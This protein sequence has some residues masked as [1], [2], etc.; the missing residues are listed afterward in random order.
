[1]LFRS[2]RKGGDLV[3]K[4]ASATNR[5]N[6]ELD[7][8]TRDEVSNAPSNVRVHR[9]LNSNDPK[10]MQLYREADLFV[11][12]TR[13]DCHSLASLE[14]MASGIPVILARSGGTGDII[15][16]GD[17][18]YLIE[19][20]KYDE[21]AD[22]LDHLL[23]HPET[24]SPMGRAARIDAVK[25]FDAKTNIRRTIGIMRSAIDY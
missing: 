25:R 18:G 1:M 22:R 8:V 14:A 10:L 12:P 3:V 17:T 2:V 4:W 7:I 20:G 5:R 16:E 13:A 9:G 24:I 23:D 19:A 11:L 15:M 21:L 6:W